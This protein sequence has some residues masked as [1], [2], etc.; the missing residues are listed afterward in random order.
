MAY[1]PDNDDGF[2]TLQ[3]LCLSEAATA[4]SASQLLQWL[5][6]R[7]LSRTLAGP[8]RR[9]A[10]RLAGFDHA[11]THRGLAQ[12]AAEITQ[13]WT[14]QLEL[15]HRP[16]TATGQPTLVVAN[17]PGLIDAAA[18]LSCLG[19]HEIRLLTADRPMLAA[20]PALAE[21][22]IPVDSGHRGRALRAARRHLAGG[23]TLVLFPAGRIEPDPAHARDEARASLAGWSRSAAVLAR[24]VPGTRIVPVAIEGVIAPRA[25]RHLWIRATRG[26]P[27]RRDW[28]AATCQ[29]LCPDRYRIAPSVRFASP[30]DAAGDIHTRLIDTMQA[31]YA[32]ARPN[33]A[34]ASRPRTSPPR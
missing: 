27:A 24:Q 14:S 22:L 30:V 12:A 8:S 10:A 33:P 31:L 26:D 7:S 21:H 13:V 32:S 5:P 25:R 15:H 2:T 11:I 23:G 17:H 29:A 6:A 9:F 16:P 34:D 18:L 19:G 1:F 3:A 20:L 4:L 28:L